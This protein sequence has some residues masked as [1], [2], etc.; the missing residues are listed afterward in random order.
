MCFGYSVRKKSFPSAGVSVGSCSE[1]CSCHVPLAEISSA[2]SVLTSFIFCLSPPGTKDLPLIR[3][4]YSVLASSE[5]LPL[6][7]LSVSRDHTE[8]AC[9]P[10]SCELGFSS[11]ELGFPGGTVVKNPPANAGEAGL[12]P[13]LGRSPGVGN[14]NPFQY[15]CL[16]NFSGRGAWWPTVH[17]VT[18][19]RTQ[20]RD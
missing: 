2:A 3:T 20:L 13:G 7:S 15:S 18:R 9:S 16:E 17:G 4:A 6:S 10:C 11:G 12:L 14:G 19:S 1:V 8:Q 5:H